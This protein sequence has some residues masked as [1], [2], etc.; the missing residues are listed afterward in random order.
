[1]MMSKQMTSLK[2]VN[3]IQTGGCFWEEKWITSKPF[4]LW[5]PNLAAFPKNYL[6]TFLK[7]SWRTRSLPQ[8][9]PLDNLF[10]EGSNQKIRKHARGTNRSLSFFLLPRLPT[11]Q[12]ALCG[13]ERDVYVKIDVNYNTN[14][15]SFDRCF[16]KFALIFPEKK[17][18]VF[19]FTCF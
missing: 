12:R 7:S 8:R 9:L 1:M 16:S 15:M 11:T 6:A 18:F 5:P 19:R 4:R 13:G 14:C 3:P 2:L 10:K 17:T